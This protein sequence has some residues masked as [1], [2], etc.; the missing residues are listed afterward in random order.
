MVT[1]AL[2]RGLVI[3]SAS[4]KVS[5]AGPMCDHPDAEIADP[6]GAKEVT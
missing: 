3:A 5:P 1:D 4:N 6:I 2:P